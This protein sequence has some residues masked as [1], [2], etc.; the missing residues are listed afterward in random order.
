MLLVASFAALPPTQPAAA[1]TTLKLPFPGG[2]TWSVLQGYNGNPQWGGSHYNCDPLTSL[3]S[4]GHTVS[5][6]QY[7]QYK[8][9]F[10]L[11]SVGGSTAGQ[12]VL[13]PVNG[14]I[15]W[16]DTYYGGMSIDLGNG[17]AVAYFHT[18]LAPG[19]AAGQPIRQGQYL[20]TVAGPGDGGNGGT[21]H[22]HLTLWATNDGGNW[23]RIATPFTGAYA[24]EGIGFPALSDSTYN[25]YQGRQI[26]SSNASASAVA[27]EAPG[28][29]VLVSPPTGTTY[30][31][32]GVKPTLTWQS[33]SG[34]SEYQVTVND[35]Q[36]TSGW[37]SGT[38]W[39]MPALSAGQYSWQ[40]RSRNSAGTSNYSAKWV[41]WV[42]PNPSAPTPTPTPGS[43]QLGIS[44]SAASGGVGN[45]VTV[46]GAGYGSNETVKVYWD[47]QSSTALGSTTANSSGSW[48]LQIHVPETTGGQHTVIGRGATTTKRATAGFRVNPALARVPY[49]GT[50]GTPIALTVHGFGAN[51]TVKVT[52][53]S[54]SGPT[55]ATVTT[56]SR[57]MGTASFPMPEAS[58]GWHDYTGYGQTTGLR[59]W[60]A[61]LV[62][63]GAT[64]SPTSG[65]P[66]TT[67]N[68]SAKGMQGSA[69]IAAAWNGTPTNAGTTVCSGTTSSAGNYSCS[70]KIPQSGAGTFPVLVRSSDGTTA[71]ATIV[72]LG[73]P[74][75]TLTPNQ[76]SVGTDLAISAGGFSG[77]ESLI[78]TWD[79]QSTAWRTERADS[80]GSLLLRVTVP[81][82]SAGPHT[83]KVRGQSSGKT[84][85]ASFKVLSGPTSGDT[86]MIGP[87]T[88]AI[89]A[90]REGL[91][92]GTTSNGHLIVPNDHFVSLPAC[93]A[94]SCPWRTP[95]ATGANYAADCGTNCYVRVTNPVTKQCSV[96]PVY[97]VGPWFTND[98]WWD[99]T[100][101][102]N[103]N[104]LSTT[105]NILA[106]GY[107]GADAAMNKLDVGYGTAS[108][109]RGISNVGYEVANRAALDIGDGTWADVGLDYDAGIAPVVVT[110]LWQTGE[111]RDTAASACGSGGTGGNTVDESQIDISP[112][113]GP[114]GTTI[115]VN[116]AKFK[117]GETVG[118]YWDSTGSTA[119]TKVTANSAGAF[120][121]S[122]KAPAD[123]DGK[124][125]VA[126]KGL[127]SGWK[128][129]R[130]YTL[131]KL[132]NG[133]DASISI[134]PNSG[135]AGTTIKVSGTSFRAGEQV[136]VYWDSTGSTPLATVTASSAGAF[137]ATVKA[138]AG[139]TGRHLIAA[140][141]LSSEWKASRSYTLEIESAQAGADAGITITPS[142]GPT[143]VKIYVSGAGFGP[144]EK[145]GVYWDSTGST[146]LATA[147]A[148]SSGAF[149][150]TVTAQ[151]GTDGR[152]L[153]AAKGLSTGWKASRSFTL[154]SWQATDQSA[155]SVDPANGAADTAVVVTGQNFLPNEKVGV[156][157]DS[158]GSTALTTVTADANGR[159]SATVRATGG[160]AGRH[161]IATK[162]L[163]SGWKASRSFTIA[164]SVTAKPDRGDAGT[165]LQITAQGFGASETVELRWETVSGDV[166][167]TFTTDANGTGNG[168]LTIPANASLGAHQFVA[169]GQQSGAKTIGA[170]RVTTSTPTVIAS[171]ASGYVGSRINL[172]VGG[173][174]AKERVGVYWDSRTDST[175]SATTDDAGLVTFSAAVPTMPGGQ[176][177]ITLKGATSGKTATASFTITPS[178]TLSAA[179][180]ARGARVTASGKGWTTGTTVSVYWNRSGTRTGTLLC[181]ATVRSTGSVDCSFVTPSGTNGQTYP[182][183]AIS[184]ST[185]V[186]ASLTINGVSA[187]AAESAPAPATA[188][189]TAAAATPAASPIP[190]SP[191]A[192][193]SP[194]WETGQ[195]AATEPTG[196]GATATAG[197]TET[198]TDNEVTVPASPEPAQVE[199]E[200]SATATNA[201][202]AEPTATP[203]ET[204]TSAPTATPTVEPTAPPTEEPTATPTEV[205]TPAPRQ[206]VVVAASDTSVTAAAPDEIRSPDQVGI[207]SAGG[208]DGAVAYLTFQVDGI[209][210]GAVTDAQLVVTGAGDAG[211]P[212]GVIGA[213]PGFWADEGTLTYRSAP[214]SGFAP[215]VAADGSPAAIDWI[216]PGVEASANVTGTVTADGTITFVITGSPDQIVNLAS[217]ESDAPAR[218]VITVQDP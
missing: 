150:A 49:E 195:P 157:W 178:L 186:S 99:P 44:L 20:G 182:V 22:L 173:F 131:G 179:S 86:S 63:P 13:S 28:V 135:P 17:Y 87:G 108:S 117:P 116:G 156:Y 175:S 54:G 9:S 109:G 4:V 134:S 103:L 66:G 55:L 194:G 27:T 172:T 154:G 71:T 107:T 160:V 58:S 84:A 121:T 210:A 94:L 51:E 5:C 200:P 174:A 105:V 46:S 199:A 206:L 98:N 96:A 67:I 3:D 23:S 215:A 211:G 68:L 47:T 139:T 155:I 146:P 192:T 36:M 59:A 164:P 25:Q 101:S 26:T 126:A 62:K 191:T 73:A 184:G 106:Q 65:A 34:A 33:V 1:A 213:L 214:T 196:D 169:I 18:Y 89:T 111:N 177:T 128:A 6:S 127:S 15:R 48:S 80:N 176:H 132:A 29:P 82:L 78:F 35:G 83:L 130:T 70:F 102:R 40:A 16:I 123:S 170:I 163:T 162:G 39:Q 141:G 91:V 19:L 124:H 212:I 90:T 197:P 159:I 12:P 43:G 122:I 151:S 144:G 198:S 171:P 218:L 113:A 201:A 53:I 74:A 217:R 143:G 208:P 92:G 88:Y 37:I 168:S 61:L 75:V 69:P 118:I 167:S 112:L 72:V 166:L 129:S 204:P 77:N 193:A 100:E 142:G 161:L 190:S 76:G 24:L 183:V 93:T 7:W 50:P 152:H 14:V 10:D 216:D 57:G 185:S 95:G 189:A 119:L 32:T 153:I 120:S 2:T 60:G 30:A 158:T 149:S 21:P 85:S 97:D 64:A 205:P 104:N 145:V 147:T 41:F 137:T 79:S 187:T 207:L 81:Q 42:D 11:V 52:F 115:Q 181:S 203:T 38:S 148:D 136:G 31:N 138:Q 114:A 140:K 45:A 133:D 188:T 56:D 125:L 202:T 209:A 110:L 165:A 180:A 8:Y